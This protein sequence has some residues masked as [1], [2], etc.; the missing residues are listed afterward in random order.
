MGRMTLNEQSSPSAPSP[1]IVA[2]LERQVP[3]SHT[4]T[5]TLTPASR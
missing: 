2:V 4:P 1:G 5:A 3:L